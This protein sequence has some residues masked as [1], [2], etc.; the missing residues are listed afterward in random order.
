VGKS[1]SHYKPIADLVFSPGSEGGDRLLSIGQDRMLVEYDVAGS[2]VDEGLRLLGQPVKTEQA[3]TPTA[4][5]W[6][7]SSDSASEPLLMTVGPFVCCFA[8]VFI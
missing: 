4:F 8:F 6:Y 7:P 5:T 1:R 3:A 2:S